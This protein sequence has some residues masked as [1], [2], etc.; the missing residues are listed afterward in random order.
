MYCVSSMTINWRSQAQN[1]AL[2]RKVDDDFHAGETIAQA[3]DDFV[4]QRT[5]RPLGCGMDGDFTGIEAR[6][7]QQARR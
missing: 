4:D 5:P 3:G 7:G 2:V 1:Q 6:R